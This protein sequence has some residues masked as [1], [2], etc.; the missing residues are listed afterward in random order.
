MYRFILFKK[1]RLRSKYLRENLRQVYEKPL[2]R[3]VPIITCGG[4]TEQV[5]LLTKK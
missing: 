5:L 2:L 3:K 4:L 1:K